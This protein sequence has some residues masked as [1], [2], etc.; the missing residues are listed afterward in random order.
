MNNQDIV[1]KFGDSNQK[2]GG[3]VPVWIAYEQIGLQV[4]FQNKDWADAANPLTHI[5]LFEKALP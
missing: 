2:G 3:K 5:S 4:N 1:R